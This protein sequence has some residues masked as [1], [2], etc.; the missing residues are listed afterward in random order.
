[1]VLALLLIVYLVLVVMAASFSWY[2]LLHMPVLDLRMEPTTHP[3]VSIIVPVRNEATVVGRCADSLLNLDYPKKEVIF[4][5]GGSTDGTMEVLASKA[6]LTLLEEPPLPA[7]WI[8]KNWGCHIGFLA[9]KGELLLFSDGDTV[10]SREGL[11]AAVAYMDSSGADLLTLYPRLIRKGFWEKLML[12]V[13][14]F[15]I[16]IRHRGWMVNRDDKPYF[17][18]V[19]PFLLVRRRTYEAVGGHEAVKDRI[20]EDLRLGQRVK[21]NGFRLRALRGEEAVEL[22]MYEHL[23]ELWEGWVKNIA[24][25]LDY[26]GGK[27]AFAIFLALFFFLTPFAILGSGIALALA[28]RGLFVL[29][30]GLAT[31]T[32]AVTSLAPLY[33]ERAKDL[34]YP[35]LLPLAALIFI[36]MAATSFYLH[37]FGEGVTWK[38]RRYNP[39]RGTNGGF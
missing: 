7:G 1:M 20:D 32:I 27:V 21:S 8:G 17:I 34:P 9:S 37:R 24:P 6:G 29:A 38:G 19:G 5:D 30:I 2:L 26:N 23:P 3:L 33:V 12:P 14:V 28:G 25:G 4:V 35:F 31:T 10:H 13:I 22:R 15:L 11:K 39:S 16:A 36:A 18:G